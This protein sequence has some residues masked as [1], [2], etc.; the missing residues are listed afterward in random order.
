M[1][2]QDE[3]IEAFVTRW[4]AAVERQARGDGEQAVY[5]A[6]AER[7]GLLRAIHHNPGA[8]RLAANPLLLTILAVIARP[9][10]S[11]SGR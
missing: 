1:D 8:R 7:E 11:A 5:A 2:F 4:T 10:C 3:E 6:A 9:P